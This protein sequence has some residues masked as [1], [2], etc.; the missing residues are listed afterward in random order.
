MTVSLTQAT[1]PNIHAFD[2]TKE[3]CY[4]LKKLIKK[5]NGD[6]KDSLK[7]EYPELCPNILAIEDSNLNCP[8]DFKERNLTKELKESV[9]Q[10]AKENYC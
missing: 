3:F 7:E 5:C 9:V 10:Y 8:L 4:V 6:K 1:Y 2:K